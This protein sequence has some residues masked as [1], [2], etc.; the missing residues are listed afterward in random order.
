MLFYTHLVFLFYFI[1]FYCIDSASAMFSLT[2]SLSAG[3]QL[4]TIPGSMSFV[5]YAARYNNEKRGE[6]YAF[7]SKNG[8]LTA[9][10]VAKVDKSMSM[11]TDVRYNNMNHESVFQVGIMQKRNAYQYYGCVNSSGHVMS[12]VET[13]R[14]TQ[15]HAAHCTQMRMRMRAFQSSLLS[16]THSRAFTHSIDVCYIYTGTRS[17]CQLL[18]VRNDIARRLQ[19]VCF[20]NGSQPRLRFSLS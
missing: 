16:L 11:A 7:S 17:R 18:V 15:M 6:L 14:V 5:N 3:V 4:Y 13:V 1:F 8:T 20:R 2:R 12:L 9:S 19:R 10:Y